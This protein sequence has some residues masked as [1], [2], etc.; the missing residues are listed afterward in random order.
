MPTKKHIICI[1]NNTFNVIKASIMASYCTLLLSGCGG[2]SEELN[3]DNLVS[4]GADIPLN[5]TPLENNQQ[6]DESQPVELSL[7]TQGVGIENLSYTWEVLFENENIAIQGQDTDTISFTA[8]EV[9]QDAN[10]FVNVVIRSDDNT[11]FDPI[12]NQ[13]QIQVVDLTPPL[14]ES[15]SDNGASTLLPLVN[16]IDLSNVLEAST[17][18]INEYKVVNNAVENNDTE[19]ETETYSY[20]IGYLRQNTNNQINVQYCTTNQINPIRIDNYSNNI[21]CPQ[22]NVTTRYYQ[23]NNSFR[24][25]S[26]CNN[27]IVQAINYRKI[28]STIKKSF[29]Q[30]SLDFATHNDLKITENVC[31]AIDVTRKS[32]YSTPNDTDENSR[33]TFTSTRINLASEYEGAPINVHLFLD[34]ELNSGSYFLAPAMDELPENAFTIRSTQLPSLNS[35]IENDNGSILLRAHSEINI[36]GSFDINITD[37]SEVEES[38]K[39]EFILKLD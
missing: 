33:F 11:L 26:I 15:F 22:N 31:G 35:I 18:L 9:E 5:Y 17:W 27:E 37:I 39:G 12:E 30:L 19:T 4:L 8:P 14:L 28:S 2:S 21:N 16:S 7:N 32:T 29:G 34:D 20:N 1:T 24:I 13:I 25:E 10:I 38:V 36:D 3:D 23:R 6:V